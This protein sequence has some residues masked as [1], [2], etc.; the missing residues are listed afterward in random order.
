M[1]RSFDALHLTAGT[2]GLLAGLSGLQHGFFET[3]QGSAVPEG[4][5]IYAIGPGQRFW[6]SGG[7]PAM[8]LM[9]NFL[10]SGLAA[11]LISL[12]MM[13]WSARFLSHKYGSRGLL[14]LALFQLVCGGGFAPPIL[15]GLA[16]LAADRIG[17]PVPYLPNVLAAAWPW[18]YAAFIAAFLLGSELAIFGF[19]FGVQDPRSI[20]YAFA[21]L[22]P[23]SFILAV[24]C[25]LANYRR[26]AQGRL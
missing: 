9:P 2:A 6:A 1:P 13:V 14:L 11:M 15:A 16:A 21:G 7:E 12:G 8:T 20:L 24:I 19:F 26:Q 5:R 25:A 23:G 17:H 10:A 4:L 22:I 18:L 3:L